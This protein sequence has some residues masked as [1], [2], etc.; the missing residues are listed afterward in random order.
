MCVYMLLMLT[1][2][3]YI[4]IYIYKREYYIYIYIF[5]YLF[6]YWEWWR[7]SCQTLAIDEQVVDSNST[8]CAKI[9]FS[10][11]EINSCCALVPRG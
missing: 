6:I 7:S 3:I 9:H 1:I 2:Y 11:V 8:H 5:I 10:C 4:Y